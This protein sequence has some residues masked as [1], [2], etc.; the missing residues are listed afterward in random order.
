MVLKDRLGCLYGV[1]DAADG[2]EV[3]AAGAADAIDVA[4]DGRMGELGIGADD[5]HLTGPDLG[6]QERLKAQKCRETNHKIGGDREDDCQEELHNEVQTVRVGVVRKQGLEL[7]V[8]MVADEQDVEV[9]MK[10]WKL[11]KEWKEGYDDVGELRVGGL[12]DE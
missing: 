9:A 3:G 8:A 12:E 4:D 6:Q 2:V 10:E 5:G 1:G 11:E 7:N